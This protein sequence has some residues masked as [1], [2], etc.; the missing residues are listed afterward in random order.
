[1]KQMEEQYKKDVTLFYQIFT[2]KKKKPAKVT[3]FEDIELFLSLRF[4][5]Q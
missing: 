3:S 5:F 1:M 2:G 4:L